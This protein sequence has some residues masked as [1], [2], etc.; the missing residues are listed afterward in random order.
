MQLPSIFDTDTLPRRIARVL[1]YIAIFCCTTIAIS[2]IVQGATNES[3]QNITVA[4][5]RYAKPKLLLSLNDMFKNTLI[6]NLQFRALFSETPDASVV[7][8]TVHWSRVAEQLQRLNKLQPSRTLN[9]TYCAAEILLGVKFMLLFVDPLRTERKTMV[10][11]LRQCALF[12]EKTLNL[13]EQDRT[14][15]NLSR[16]IAAV[17]GELADAARDTARE[18][19]G[20]N[21][22]FLNGQDMKFVQL[23]TAYRPN[24]LLFEP[25]ETLLPTAEPTQPPAV[26]T[27]MDEI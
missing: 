26:N 14:L 15:C 27:D 13:W 3:A 12:A 24:A 9:E 20:G 23:F 1:T 22:R 19:E 5:P 18:L 2:A 16:P 17:V 6:D 25:I 7:R 8:A 21:G 10:D 11:V 4:I